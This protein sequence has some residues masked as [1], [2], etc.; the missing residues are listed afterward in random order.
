[1]TESNEA[2]VAKFA[3]KIYFNFERNTLLFGR[4][5][6]GAEDARVGKGGT[7]LIFRTESI[8]ILSSCRGLRAWR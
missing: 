8:S 2:L 3:P 1:V 5:L 7:C 6:L 4:W